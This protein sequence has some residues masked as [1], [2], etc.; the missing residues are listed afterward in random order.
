LRDEDVFMIGGDDEDEDGDDDDDD[1]L[2]MAALKAMDAVEAMS[3]TQ[4]SRGT[5]DKPRKQGMHGKR[6]Q[7]AHIPIDNLRKLI[8]LLLL[9]SPLEPT[10]PLAVFVDRFTGEGL[11]GLKNAAENVLNAFTDG[12]R[13]QRGVGWRQFKAIMK[14]STVCFYFVSFSLFIFKL[15][16]SRRLTKNHFI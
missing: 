3:F 10:Q 6:I 14:R 1:D 15:D 13:S 8:M 2:T 9:I 4:N 11:A 7:T 16:I 5:K 12:N